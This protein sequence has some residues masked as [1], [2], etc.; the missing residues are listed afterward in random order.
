MHVVLATHHLEY[1][2]PTFTWNVQHAAV[3][4]PNYYAFSILNPF[5]KSDL[6]FRLFPGTIE[7]N[8][9]SKSEANEGG[10]SLF[11]SAWE[12]APLPIGGSVLLLLASASACGGLCYYYYRRRKNASLLEVQQE[13]T[14]GGDP[15][16]SVS[17]R[18]SPPERPSGEEDAGGKTPSSPSAAAIICSLCERSVSPESWGSGHH[19]RKCASRRKETLG[20]ME[21][22]HKS[23]RCETDGCNKRLKLWPARL[24]PPFVCSGSDCAVIGQIQS[25]GTNRFSCF[26]CDKSL[27]DSCARRRL[28]DHYPSSSSSRRQRRSA[29][30]QSCH[31][32]LLYTS[33]SPRD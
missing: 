25:N 13:R 28:R 19:R 21:A 8:S 16:R 7:Y 6:V 11:F 1:N 29:R 26:L 33:P 22:P 4:N 12:W 32:C 18:R 23:L 5:T 27:C 24:G 20:A 15:A 3:I 17:R 14:A 10:G 31:P 30:S 9:S 2:Q